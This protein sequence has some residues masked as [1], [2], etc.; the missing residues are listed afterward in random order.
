MF[1]GRQ[2]RAIELLARGE[3]TQEEVAEHLG[4]NPSTLSRWKKR[5]GFM[6]AV[7]EKSREQLRHTL[8]E[9][10][11]TLAK[12]SKRGSDRHIKILLDHIEKLEQMKANSNETT[13]IFKW[14]DED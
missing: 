6:E 2:K 5:P 7:V 4:I 10:Y 14:K 8:P 13:I 9:I 12:S 1:N 3:N 11:D